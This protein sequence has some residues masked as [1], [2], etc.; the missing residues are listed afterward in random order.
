MRELPIFLLLL[1]ILYLYLIKIACSLHLPDG[2]VNSYA[3]MADM[4][5]LFN[6]FAVSVFAPSQP[7][8]RFFRRFGGLLLLPVRLCR[9]SRSVC[10]SI[11]TV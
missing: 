2:G 1:G 7:L 5:Y 10:A 3:V 9:V 11:T 6:L 4:L 8:A